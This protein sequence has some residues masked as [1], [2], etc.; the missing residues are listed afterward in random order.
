M[1]V[2]ADGMQWLREQRREY[3]WVAYGAQ[4]EADRRARVLGEPGA[5]IDP[6]EHIM[7]AT[8]ERKAKDMPL[9]GK[10]FYL[11]TVDYLA[12]FRPLDA[13][14]RLDD[15]ALLL[16]CVEEDVVTP[17]H[18]A[19]ELF[20]ATN[21]PKRLLVQRG[22]T[23]YDAYAVNFDVLMTQFIEWYGRYVQTGMRTV[24]S[25]EPRPSDVIEIPY[26]HELK[27]R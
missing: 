1:T 4:L 6:T 26:A 18:H 21:S 22:V 17:E 8:P 9:R 10:E 27:A 14:R 19:R 5:L 2:V 11:A 24:A 15:C 16:T 3:E 7:V 23:H 12:D 20:A 25:A 13:A